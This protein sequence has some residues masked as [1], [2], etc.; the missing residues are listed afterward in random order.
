MGNASTTDWVSV[1]RE[2]GLKAT[3]IRVELLALLSPDHRLLSVDEIHVALKKGVANRT[4]IYRSIQSFEEVGLIVSTELGDGIVRYELRHRSQKSPAH[5]HHHHLVCRVCHK[6]K[7][8][9]ECVVGKVPK[10]IRDEGYSDLDHRLDFF[11][12]CPRCQKAS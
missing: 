6:V 5:H 10:V 7:V 9:E 8:V 1:L 11:G 3:P 4:T 12:V 2:L